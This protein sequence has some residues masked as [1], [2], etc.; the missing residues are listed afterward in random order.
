M[1]HIKLLAV[2]FDERVF[3]S[4]MPRFPSITHW[5]SP[6]SHGHS[7]VSVKPWEVH[8]WTITYKQMVV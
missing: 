8:T 2:G 6:C 5:F 3:Q 4:D 1:C 7:K